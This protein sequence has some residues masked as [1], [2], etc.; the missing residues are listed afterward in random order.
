MFAIALKLERKSIQ[1]F[2][3]VTL[4][5]LGLF[6]FTYKSTQF[7]MTGFACLM[8]ASL[9]SGIRWSFMQLLLQKP[10]F[11]T[12][13]N[14]IQML[15]YIQPFMIMTEIVLAVVIERFHFIEAIFPINDAQHSVQVRSIVIVVF[16]GFLAFLL[17]ISEIV[18]VQNTSSLTLSIAGIFKVSTKK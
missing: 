9:F 16:G 3:T 14:P 6:L 4:M 2:S 5:A 10:Q 17:A 11:K 15:M 12:I 13:S 18:V 8:L 7:N 1:L